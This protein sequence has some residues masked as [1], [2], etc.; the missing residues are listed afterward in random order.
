MNK[1]I[2][3]GRITKDLELRRT[4]T[5]LAYCKFTLAVNRMF[6]KNNEAD[7]I[8]CVAWKKTAENLVKYMGK[9]SQIGVVGNIQTGSYEKNGQRVYTTEVNCEQIH[10]LDN[11]KERQE[12]NQ[13]SYYQNNNYNNTSNNNQDDDVSP[14]N[15][16][17]DDD[18]PF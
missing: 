8:N 16:L 15:F 5:N 12:N 6:S 18:M 10:F 4:N 17:S 2:L 11:K 14:N 9:G 13:D 1:V 7:F 3:I